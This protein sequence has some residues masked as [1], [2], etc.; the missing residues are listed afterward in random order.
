MKKKKLLISYDYELF[1]GDRSGTVLNTLIEPTNRLMEAMEK[2]GL[3]GNFFVDWQMLKYLK[4]EKD[5]RCQNDYKL[6]E[7]QLKDIIRRGHR[8]EL[9]IHPHW[10]NAKY[11]GDGTWDYKDFS[12]YSLQS[13]SE[14]EIIQMFVEGTQLLTSIAQEIDPEYR[15]IAFRAGGW[16]I[17]PFEK[18]RKGFIAAGIKIDSSTSYGISN[19]HKYSCYD[20]RKMPY[21]SMYHFETDVCSEIQSGQFLEIPITS[22]HIPFCLYL[23]ERHYWK[24]NIYTPYADGTHLRSEEPT[25]VVDKSLANR[26]FDKIKKTK[27]N[28]LSFSYFSPLLL[29]YVAMFKNGNIHCLIDHPKD[30]TDATIHNIC[31]IGDYYES[32]LYKDLITEDIR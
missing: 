4:Q 14:N 12:H 10:V 26:I 20:F 22:L 19:K 28:M 13:F 8:I 32:L 16:A 2:S 6:I 7:D 21:K 3:R 25:V 5:I 15:I 11:N 1:F 27:R 24:T 17:Q 9:H 29:K 23:Y 30:V 18:L 31:C